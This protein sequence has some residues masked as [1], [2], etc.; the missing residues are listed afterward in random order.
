MHIDICIYGC[1]DSQANVAV[2]GPYLCNPQL[3]L[4]ASQFGRS[5]VGSLLGPIQLLGSGH[6]GPAERCLRFRRIPKSETRNN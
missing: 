3:G 6:C 5:L 1:L 2:F 4:G